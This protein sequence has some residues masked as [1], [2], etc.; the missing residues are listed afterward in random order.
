M[1]VTTLTKKVMARNEAK[2]QRSL[3]LLPKDQS[4]PN[5]EVT[6]MT[7]VNVQRD[8]PFKTSPLHLLQANV[9]NG[10]FIVNGRAMDQDTS[11]VTI[12]HSG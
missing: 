11:R 7:S 10:K 6:I 9:A 3:L 1:P 5:V 4:V 2:L 8:W 12:E